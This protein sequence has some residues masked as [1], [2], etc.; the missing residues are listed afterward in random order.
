MNQQD[1]IDPAANS[2]QHCLNF[3]NTLTLHQAVE[4]AVA[5]YGARTAIRSG[6]QCLTF[7][8]FNR[9]ANLMAHEMVS[10]GV[11]PGDR[12]GV[13]LDRNLDNYLA[14][15][16]VMKTGAAYL[17]LEPSL[18][19][20]RI[21]AIAEQAEMALVVSQ[22][23]YLDLAVHLS[24]N[25]YNVERRQLLKRH[26]DEN[27]EVSVAPS[28]LAYMIFT[29]GSTGSPKGVAVTHA[30]VISMLYAMRAIE[31]IEDNECWLALATLAFDISVTETF[32]PLVF[33]GEL[34][35]G[36]KEW[37]FEPEKI[38]RVALQ[39]NVTMIQQTPSAWKLMMA[40]RW[41]A[42]LKVKMI[43]CGEA[44]GTELVRE[45][46]PHALRIWNC[47]GPTEAT[48]YASYFEMDLEKTVTLQPGGAVPVGRPILNYQLYVLDDQLQ[49]VGPND[50]GQL[51]IGGAGVASHYWRNPIQTAENFI[52][53]PFSGRP[54]A[55]IYN[56]RDL[57]KF[58][59]DGAI[60]YMA[61]SDKQ[62]KIHGYRVELGDV[63]SVLIRHE[64]VN[65]AVVAAVNVEQHGQQLVAYLVL[66]DNPPNMGE[67]R[68][69]LNEYLP[70]YMVPAAIEV[71]DELPL[72][73]SGKIDRK[74]LPAPHFDVRW[75]Q[76]KPPVNPLESQLLEVWQ[77]Q[78]G[79]TDFG[80]EDNFFM[81]GGHSL[82]AIGL[83]K[84]TMDLTGQRVNF[85]D[86]I[87][88]PTIRKLARKMAEREAPA[89][90]VSKGLISITP[91][92]Q[93]HFEP[94]DLSPI[95][96][97]YWIGC[98]SGMSMGGAGCY[99]YLE[100]DLDSMDH[101]RLTVAINRLFER[102]D[103]LRVRFGDEG[104][105]QVIPPGMPVAVPFYSLHEL[106]DTELQRKLEA[107]ARE[108]TFK[109]SPFDFNCVVDLRLSQ[110]A[111]EKWRL[112]TLVNIAVLD[113][114][115][116]HVFFNELAQLIEN[117]DVVLEPLRV[118][119]RDYL[120]AEEATGES[121][122]S[123]RSRIYWQDRVASLPPAPSL[124][125]VKSP[126]KVKDPFF[127][128]RIRVV[129]RERW[130]VL[131][132]IAGHNGVT[133]S[134]MLLT[135]FS[136]VIGSWSQS[137]HFILNLTLFNRYS[138]HDQIDRILGNFTSVNLLEVKHR[139]ND[140]FISRAGAIQQRLW[141]DLDNRF[142]S[143]IEVLRDMNRHSGSE[144]QVL[145]PIVFN[146]ELGMERSGNH[147][148]LADKLTDRRQGISQTPQVWMDMGVFE[149]AGELVLTIDG[150]DE[151]FPVRMLDD[152]LTCYWENLEWLA[153]DAS[154]WRQGRLRCMPEAQQRIRDEVN[155]I[156][157]PVPEVLLH[158]A[159][160]HQ[161]HL[162]P[163]AGAVIT[164]D[165]QIQYGQLN[166]AAN[167]LAAQL[168]RNGVKVNELVAVL[169]HRGWEQVV[170]VMGILK[171]G[172]A[173]LP[174]NAD[175]PSSRIELLL[176]QS[177]ARQIVT[178]SDIRLD[179][180]LE[181]NFII[182]LV[183]SADLQLRG[184]ENPE[185]RAQ[186][187]DLAYVIFTSGST[188]VPKGVAIDHR[189]AGNT[190]NSIQQKFKVT[191]KDSVLALSSLSFDLSVYDI[192]G[193]LGIGGRVVIPDVKLEKDPAHWHQLVQDNQITLWNTVPALMQM[194]IDHLEFI[195]DGG[196]KTL[197]QVMMSGD[198]I[199][200]NLPERIRGQLPDAAIESMGGATEA[201]IWSIAFTIGRVEP[202]WNSIPYGKPLA[203]QTYH[204]FK[205]DLSPCP[206]WVSGELYIGGIGVAKGYWG[207]SEK[208]ASHFIRDPHT[209]EMLYRTGDLGRY[210]PDGNIE[211]QGRADT[212][213]KILGYRIEL[214]E[215]EA[216]LTRCKQVR[217]SLVIACNRSGEEGQERT[218]KILIAYVVWGRPGGVC[219]EVSTKAQEKT[220]FKLKRAGLRHGLTEEN[221]IP[222]MEGLPEDGLA[223]RWHVNVNT[224]D[225]QVSTRQLSA[226]LCCLGEISQADAPLPKF[227]YPSSGGLN[228]V[229]AYLQVGSNSVEGVAAGLYYHDPK[230]HRLLKVADNEALTPATVR[231][232][233][234]GRR[235]AV[236]P[237]YDKYSEFLCQMEAGYM[238]ELL[239]MTATAQG[240][241]TEVVGTVDDALLGCVGCTAYDW[242]LASVDI[243]VADIQPIQI[244][245][246][247]SAEQ[248]AVALPAVS[249]YGEFK[250]GIFERQS[251]RSFDGYGVTLDA[252][253]RLL[254]T[255]PSPDLPDS[256]IYVGIK[257]DGVANLAAGYYRYDR[258]LHQLWPVLLT[259]DI[260][261]GL[262]YGDNGETYNKSA[263][264][265]YMV[266][267]V[268]QPRALQDAG[269]AG[270]RYSAYGVKLLLGLCAIGGFHQQP[271]VE[272]LGLGDGITILHSMLGGSI[273]PHQAFQ[274]LQ[275]TET[276]EVHDF[277]TLRRQ[278]EDE[279]PHY[280]LPSVFVELDK[281]PLT[282][283]GKV[284]RKRLPAPDFSEHKQK[285]YSAPVNDIQKALAFL[286][287]EALGLERC[288]IQDHFFALGGTSAQLVNMR[289]QI[290][291]TLGLTVEVADLFRYSTIDALAGHLQ[292]QRSPRD[293][294]ASGNRQ[295]R[296]SEKLQQNAARQRQAARKAQ[297][298]REGIGATY[299][300]ARPQSARSQKGKLDK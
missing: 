135:I 296:R 210:F 255:T 198:W 12:V 132:E 175:F 131:Q 105:Q 39:H 150:L 14:L 30:N 287:Q 217:E 200:L 262:Y 225:G 282:A 298:M 151:I 236:E 20:E 288:G 27:L 169:M 32:F 155:S 256:V 118:T 91:A 72:S 267:Q 87:A 74:A 7:E 224:I 56:T 104:R 84:L 178:Q 17:P 148:E 177:E 286:W 218:D 187:T 208:T 211:F 53:D 13:Y 201:S 16:A 120:A 127:K 97:A 21:K 237:A 249:L 268:N 271:V 276:V 292:R 62:V 130:Q 77:Q 290:K 37:V 250:L 3:D 173:Y 35:I 71:L 233:L 186:V 212:Q 66:G 278:L 205:T 270:Q 124:P 64:K 230:A 9:Q 122:E 119:F 300:S 234:V 168:Q 158:Q 114:T 136:H 188:G 90:P 263:F 93:D 258:Q 195:G 96:E 146:S 247:S 19:E 294:I 6:E 2:A 78:L 46:V 85:L 57:V 179:S 49:P 126:D 274:W 59:A 140:N 240:L 264:A 231:L 299:S 92:P 1:F 167:K 134:V 216:A 138:L 232:H 95:Q 204:V 277:D 76:T 36:H 238:L 273:G 44:L 166:Q 86:I 245:R 228:P 28:H 82:M 133:P 11:G 182:S 63:E 116:M 113:A 229:Q 293:E 156:T 241:H 115:S 259:E 125:L 111:E 58:D 196:D 42:S 112:H 226:W 149:A 110:L 152:M 45:L 163:L 220:L 269:R 181:R 254:A 99:N 171:A 88:Q 189:G 253:S 139:P 101:D 275:P 147:S 80:V 43:C 5:Q 81:L 40:Q 164:R 106:N 206:D 70:Y 281:L 68:Q 190:I 117:P 89:T 284:D 128:R 121:P 170:A 69:Y 55:R 38:H 221:A 295:H 214:G 142:Y 145:M 260:G 79:K 52:P 239:G 24:D 67:L 8:Q 194:Y 197:R 162:Q 242:L 203:N 252:L 10:R 184:F 25:I 219:D 83:I 154:H 22:S 227:F 272:H 291:Q 41:P 202:H 244:E 137:N 160:E 235:H 280:M 15:L 257:P 48:V 174:I 213:V 243:K 248:G 123:A 51:Y 108:M 172:G 209:G 47:Y 265:L 185:P 107:I 23:K 165:R 183:D 61:R 285:T 18:P 141:A 153:E 191:D 144:T 109:E 73:A 100:V 251:Y 261:D 50:I 102:H 289:S 246:T 103:M 176:K 60:V 33:G 193:L 31:G 279:L 159:F 222:L 297:A 161:A 29:S 199:P 143:G 223:Q 180:K 98:F 215:I 192:F 283:N 26:S 65:F 54:G 157:I 94:F 129:P 4:R 75:Q 207:D 266:G 34:V